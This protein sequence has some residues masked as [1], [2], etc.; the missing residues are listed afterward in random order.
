MAQLE[1]YIINLRE[2]EE[3]KHELYH[4]PTPFRIADPDLKQKDSE[5]HKI[6]Q[7]MSRISKQIQLS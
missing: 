2:Q 3:F 6:T 1:A 7:K 4:K 5:L